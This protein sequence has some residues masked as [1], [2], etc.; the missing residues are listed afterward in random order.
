MRAVCGPVCLAAAL[1]ACSEDEPL[2]LPPDAE[3]VAPGYARMVFANYEDAARAVSILDTTVDALL[4]APSTASLNVAQNGWRDARRPYLQTEVYRFYGGP[5]DGG[6]A[7]PLDAIAGWPAEPTVIDYTTSSPDGGLVNDRSVP[8]EA[9]ALRGLQREDDGVVLG[10]FA[11]EYLLH[12]E[13]RDTANS[14]IRPASD[15]IQDG[16]VPDTNQDRR[17]AYLETA[18]DALEADLNTLSDAWAPDRE[19]NYRSEFEG[20]TPRQALRRILTGMT[21]LTGRELVEQRLEPALRTGEDDRELARF[22]DNTEQELGLSLGGVS[23][24]WRGRYVRTDGRFVDGVGL[25]AVVEAVDPELAAQVDSSLDTARSAAD[26]LLDP[27]D[28]EVR[29]E[30]E[31]GRARVQALVDALR[32]LELDLREVGRLLDLNPAAP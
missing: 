28:N 6:D 27:F 14:G 25:R 26:A 8:L 19:D 5:I 1:A 29:A 31:P 13:D 30:N 9:E 32:T 7:P 24:L 21:V 12:G 22:S 4:Q 3:L 11:I 15:F 10:Y 23:N 20:L 18:V 2:E 17:A 16:S